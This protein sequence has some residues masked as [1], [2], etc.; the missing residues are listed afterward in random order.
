LHEGRLSDDNWL[1]FFSCKV[2]GDVLLEAMT[3]APD[4]KMTVL[5]GHT[6]GAGEAEILPNLRVITGKAVYGEPVVQKLLD[7]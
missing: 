6:Q 3:Q 2:V 5:C 7:C 4:R 1:P